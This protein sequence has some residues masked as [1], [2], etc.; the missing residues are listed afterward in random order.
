MLYA[1]FFLVWSIICLF[2]GQNLLFLLKKDVFPKT[3]P[4]LMKMLNNISKSYFFP[5][6]SRKNSFF[7]QLPKLGQKE[8]PALMTPSKC[9]AYQRNLFGYCNF[10]D[11]FKYMN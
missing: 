10:G 6:N 9:Q 4:K 2:K 11:F 7:R 8:K 5:Q 1:L 3:M